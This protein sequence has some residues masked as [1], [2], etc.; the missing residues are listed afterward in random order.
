M[1]REAI[2]GDVEG[3]SCSESSTISSEPQDSLAKGHY[4]QRHVSVTCGAFAILAVA[5]LV[6][7]SFNA[8]AG[9]AGHGGM[10]F[11]QGYVLDLRNG[12]PL[13][14]S[15]VQV[16]GTTN[17]A[18]TDQ[19]GYYLVTLLPGTY[20]ETASLHGFT[21]QSKT[22]IVVVVNRFTWQNFSLAP[23]GNIDGFVQDRAT[24]QSLSGAIVTL[25]GT[26]YH[27]QSYGPDGYFNITDVNPGNYT[28]KS[29]KSSYYD[30]VSTYL[31]EVVSGQTSHV[32]NITMSKIIQRLP[33][34]IALAGAA[35][36]GSRA[37]IFAGSKPG[38]TYLNQIVEY[39]PATDTNF[40]VT[41]PFPQA[42]NSVSSVWIGQYSSA[43]VFGGAYYQ[44]GSQKGLQSVVKFNPSTNASYTYSVSLPTAVWGTSAVWTGTYAFIFGG[45]VSTSAHQVADIVRFDPANPTYSTK[46]SVSLPSKRAYTS[47]V[48][49][50]HYAYIF[51]GYSDTGY[52]D[53]I[54]RYD[55]VGNTVSTLSA[56]LPTPSAYSVALWDGRNI[57][58]YGGQASSGYLNTVVQFNNSGQQAAVKLQTL[59]CANGNLTGINDGYTSFLFGGQS[60]SGLSNKVV[61]YHEYGYGGNYGVDDYY[62]YAGGLVNTANGNLVIQQTDLSIMTRGPSIELT[63]TYNGMLYDTAGTYNQIK[64]CPFGLGWTS[65][66]NVSVKT[67]PYGD[68]LLTEACGSHH[69]F[70]RQPDGFFVTP[71]GLSQRLT[72]DLVTGNLTLWSLDGSKMCFDGSGRFV[73]ESDKNGNMIILTYGSSGSTNGLLLSVSDQ[74]GNSLNFTYYSLNGWVQS[75]SCA[76]EIVYYSYLSTQGGY[77]LASVSNGWTGATYYMDYDAADRLDAI[78]K[79]VEKRNLSEPGFGGVHPFDVADNSSFIFDSQGRCTEIWSTADYMYDRHDSV[80]LPMYS[81][82][83]KYLITYQ[84][85][86]STVVTCAYGHS[87]TVTMNDALI[88]IKVS[89]SPLSG[90]SSGCG[91]SGSAGVS[92]P[93][94]TGNENLTLTWDRSYRLVTSTD[95]NGYIYSYAYDAFGDMTQVTNPFNVVTKY[96]YNVTVGKNQYIALQVNSTDALGHKTRNTYDSVGNLVKSLDAS[97]NY[98]QYWYDSLGSMNK[99][100]DKRGF[101]TQYQYNS[102]G[103]VSNVTDPAGATTRIAMNA[104]GYNIT[105]TSPLG[106]TTTQVY[107][108]STN[109]SSTVTITDSN[110]NQSS[111]Q[112][113]FRGDVTASTDFSGNASTYITNITLGKPDVVTNA[114]GYSTHY[115]YSAYG[116]IMRVVDANNHSVNFTYDAYARLTG[117]QMPTGKNYTYTYDHAGNMIS[118]R[119]PNGNLTTYDY[120]RLGRLKNTTYPDGEKTMLTYDALGQVI[121]TTST[122]GWENQTY[123][124]LG[125]VTKVVTHYNQF[126][127]ARG[128]SGTSYDVTELLTYDPS[129]NMLTDKF[130]DAYYTVQANYTYDSVGRLTKITT[131]TGLWWSFTYN[132]NSWRSSELASGSGYWYNTTYHYDDN[133]NLISSTVASNGSWRPSNYTYSYDAMGRVIK[134]VDQYGTTRYAYD[135]I[136]QLIGYLNVTSG[137]WTNFSYDGVGN[138]LSQCSSGSWTNFTYNAYDELLHSS[139]GTN[140]SYD[141]NG[142][143]A[144]KTYGG[145][146]QTSSY[147]YENEL[148]GYSDTL[149]QR[150]QCNYSGTGLLIGRAANPGGGWQCERFVYSHAGSLPVAA[151]Y[152]APGGGTCYFYWNFP[153]SDE[154]LGCSGLTSPA[155]NLFAFVDGLGNVRCYAIADSGPPAPTFQSYTPF[156]EMYGPQSEWWMD[157]PSFQGKTYDSYT[158]LY[159]FQARYYDP[160]TGRFDER[161]PQPT[162]GASTYAFVMNNP[163]GGRDPTGRMMWTGANEGG[164]SPYVSSVMSTGKSWSALIPLGVPC[165][166]GSWL[167][168]FSWGTWH[169]DP[170]IFAYQLALAAAQNP[171]QA[172]S[173]VYGVITVCSGF[174]RAALYATVAVFYTLQFY[175][176]LIAWGAVGA[177]ALAFCGPS[178]MLSAAVAA[179]K[180]FKCM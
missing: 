91:G 169:F 60:A 172:A 155:G 33:T 82:V 86:T 105:V 116:L 6:A 159:Y 163:L 87:M 1:R 27:A 41:N 108:N 124:S 7:S 92:F 137:I 131:S 134:A 63:R 88:P 97:G 176:A 141:S 80:R 59:P 174:L 77:V 150:E 100:R 70:I 175:A 133:G 173:C 34:G 48:Y 136:G 170:S 10:G 126:G 18:T 128:L 103:A 23:Q 139:D 153:G 3:T 29:Q 132:Q 109:Q 66:Y 64:G 168:I 99:T 32:G 30:Y 118:R 35:W 162:Y 160:T 73:N 21:T 71:P 8:L 68:V 58:I 81:P 95:G 177:C 45:G 36:S 85:L 17:S 52:I 9:T 127:A 20:S 84:N 2:Q 121:N 138:M 165:K 51:G 146:T 147:D 76:G 104:T 142:N 11:I 112:L 161:D 5:L 69:I 19:N 42:R 120:D 125:L 113:N 55:P 135:K 37:L 39:T 171:A 140:Y 25:S 54:V 156:G 65:N 148:V 93:G 15:L 67:F 12:Q 53:Q 101:V 16:V 158:G 38:S 178:L 44:G 107:T 57:C 144:S 145:T 130:Q 94:S 117:V 50:G 28:L 22:G 164:G 75:V 72:R 79:L 96:G 90:G 14:G 83:R 115:F 46:M 43:Y 119:D 157:T 167:N 123:N 61:R 180:S 152:S 47:A 31:I 4:L 62:V 26:N 49:D 151:V 40:T 106:Q 110:G 114:L 56:K 98:T 122:S 24:F 154:V 166:K 129:G 143:Q 102:Q 13:N 89:G 78:Y 74:A 111:Q 179:A 149:G